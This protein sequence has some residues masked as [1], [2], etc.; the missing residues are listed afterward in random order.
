MLAIMK[1][2]DEIDLAAILAARLS[3]ARGGRKPAEPFIVGEPRE[4]TREDL[5]ELINPSP[6]ESTTPVLQRLRSTHHRLAQLIADGVKGV[7]ISLITG[8]SQSRISILQGDPAFQELVSFY[9]NQKVAT[10]IDVQERLADLGLAATEEIRERLEEDPSGFTVRELLEIQAG[11]L[12]RSSA[13]KKSSQKIEA[14]VS[15]SWSDMVEQANAARLAEKTAPSPVIDITPTEV[16][17]DGGN[18]HS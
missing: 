9:Q 5:E 13:P 11:A 3:P 17:N 15:H 2:D 18:N 1:N 4:L 12:D 14:T 6:K 16:K 8:Y 10:F 7:E